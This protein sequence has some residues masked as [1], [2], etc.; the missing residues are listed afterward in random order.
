MKKSSLPPATQ[1]PGRPNG[2]RRAKRL[3]SAWHVRPEA[4]PRPEEA[5]KV[6][7]AVGKIGVGPSALLGRKILSGQ[8]EVGR[9]GQRMVEGRRS[10]R[11]IA[12]A[13]TPS[14]SSVQ[15]EGATPASPVLPVTRAGSSTKS[16][17]DRRGEKSAAQPSPTAGPVLLACARN[18]IFSAQ[19]AEVIVH[20]R[21][22]GSPPGRRK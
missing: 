4:S 2:S 20:V 17:E 19:R 8:C 22:E 14:S 15:C 10:I 6:V 3:R 21:R 11:R 13:R 7:T 1:P 18:E 12:Q 9:S 5:L 16:G